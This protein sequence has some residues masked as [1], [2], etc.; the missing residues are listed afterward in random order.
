MIMGIEEAPLTENL[1]GG[2]EDPSAADS[3]SSTSG[4]SSGSLAMAADS[5]ISYDNPVLAAAAG[6]ADAC[7]FVHRV[8]SERGT[9]PLL[10]TVAP[11]LA[12]VLNRPL[13][14]GPAAITVDSTKAGGST[15]AETIMLGALL[16]AV[17][18]ATFGGC[19][20]R[21][22]RAARL[23][24]DQSKAVEAP[25]AASVAALA[26]S[27][28]DEDP[29]LWGDWAAHDSAEASS[30]SLSGGAATSSSGGGGALAAEDMTAISEAEAKA[31]EAEPY[32]AENFTFAVNDGSS[33][34]SSS[35]PSSS[36]SSSSSKGGKSNVSTFPV[37]G[38][39]VP[40]G[41]SESTLVAAAL[42]MPLLKLQAANA[43]RIAFLGTVSRL[44]T[45][46]ANNIGAM[47][48]DAQLV[49]LKG[50]E[51]SAPR[52]HRHNNNNSADALAALLMTPDF[53]ACVRLLYARPLELPPALAA[54]HAAT[55]S[56]R[57]TSSDSDGS[58]ENSSGGTNSGS[59]SNGNPALDVALSALTTALATAAPKRASALASSVVG[60]LL[61]QASSP[62]LSQVV[63]PGGGCA[64]M[65]GAGSGG[66]GGGGGGPKSLMAQPCAWDPEVTHNATPSN[67]SFRDNNTI[68]CFSN[69]TSHR[70]CYGAVGVAPGQVAQWKVTVVKQPCC[71]YVGVAKMSRLNTYDSFVDSSTCIGFSNFSGER[72]C[73]RE[74]GAYCIFR[75]DMRVGTITYITVHGERECPI[76]KSETLYPAIDSDENGE[77]KIQWDGPMLGGSSG[78]LSSDASA[79]AWLLPRT[80]EQK[81]LVQ[82]RPGLALA[83]L[84]ALLQS[85][86]SAHSNA[87]A[88][89]LKTVQALSSQVLRQEVLNAIVACVEASSSDDDD[90][91]SNSS[92]SNGKDQDELNKRAG[93][94]KLA[95]LRCVASFLEAASSSSLTSAVDVSSSSRGRWSKPQFDLSALQRLGK[96]MAWMHTQET[97]KGKGYSSYLMALVQVMASVTKAIDAQNDDTQSQIVKGR[98]SAGTSQGTGEEEFKEESSAAQE[99][100]EEAPKNRVGLNGA[101]GSEV[102][103]A[104]V[105]VLRPV[106]VARAGSGISGSSG[107][108]SPPP[109]PNCPSAQH[110][111]AVSDGSDNNGYRHFVCNGCRVHTSGFRWWC[112]HCR[113]DYCFSCHPDPRSASP[114][115]GRSNSSGGNTSSNNAASP[116]RVSASGGPPDGSFDPSTS[117]SFAAALPDWFNG[118]VH[119]AAALPDDPPL[120][121]V[122][123]AARES[124]SSSQQGLVPRSPV[125]SS[126]SS[127]SSS[128]SA[129]GSAY[130]VA[131][132][133]SMWMERNIIHDW[134]PAPVLRQ[135]IWQASSSFD[136]SYA[137]AN[138][139]VKSGKPW[140]SAAA[141]PQGIFTASLEATSNAAAGSSS[142]GSGGGRCEAVVVDFGVL[143]ELSGLR[144]HTPAQGWTGAE[145]KAL[146]LEISTVSAQGPWQPV[147]CGVAG[148]SP[149]LDGATTPSLP[150][151]CCP[152]GHPIAATQLTPFEGC[153]CSVCNREEIVGAC[154]TVYGCRSC[155]WGLCQSCYTTATTD[156][157][158]EAATKG[159]HREPARL[160]GAT[161][162]GAGA[163]FAAEQESVFPLEKTK[164][165]QD[166]VGFLSAARFWRLQFEG[167][168]GS[169]HLALQCVEFLG[170]V[171]PSLN[172]GHAACFLE[173][174][175]PPIQGGTDPAPTTSKIPDSSGG[176]SFGPIPES[177]PAPTAYNEDGKAPTVPP[178]FSLEPAGFTLE[179]W[180]RPSEA[181]RSGIQGEIASIALAGGGAVQW[182]LSASGALTLAV[183]SNDDSHDVHATSTTTGESSNTTT[184]L[185]SFEAASSKLSAGSWAHVAVVCAF[186]GSEHSSCSLVFNGEL[187]CHGGAAGSAC[188]QA[189][190]ALLQGGVGAGGWGG[191]T[192]VIGR[193]L[194]SPSP[195]PSSL[196]SSAAGAAGTTATDT[197]T[198]Q[199]FCG[200]LKELRVWRTARSS[201]AIAQYRWHKHAHPS[202]LGT[203]ARSFQ[204]RHGADKNLMVAL[205]LTGPSDSVNTLDL[206]WA[207][208]GSND[209]NDDSSSSSAVAVISR[210]LRWA[211][212]DGTVSLADA[213]ATTAAA[214]PTASPQADIPSSESN[215][216]LDPSSPSGQLTPD[217]AAAATNDE[218]ATTGAEPPEARALL[219]VDTSPLA[220]SLRLHTVTQASA[221]LAAQFGHLNFHRFLEALQG[222]P[223]GVD[224]ALVE[225]VN[226]ACANDASF[227]S[228][229]SNANASNSNNSGLDAYDKFSFGPQVSLVAYP[230]LKACAAKG[231]LNLRL[232]AAR[233]FNTQIAQLL[234]LVDLRE[235]T[236]PNTLA[237]ALVQAAPRLWLPTK[238]NLWRAGLQAT[239]GSGGSRSIEFSLNR[240][241]AA[242]VIGRRSG[243]DRVLLASVFGQLFTKVHRLPPS[244]LRLSASKDNRAWRVNFAGEGSIDAG[245]PYRESLSDA[246]GDLMAPHLALF[247]PCANQ[248]AEVEGFVSGMGG[249]QHMD[250]FVP[251]PTRQ[252]P[253]H[254]EMYQFAGKLL[255]LA[256][257]TGAALPLRFPPLFYKLLLGA[258][259]GRSDLK[260]IDK[261]LVDYLDA[262]ARAA[263]DPHMTPEL[264]EDLYGGRCFT[265]K[266]ACGAREVELLPGGSKLMLNL[267]NAS[268][269]VRLMFQYHLHEFDTQ[270]RWVAAGLATVV[271]IAVLRVFTPSQVELLV[272]GRRE[273]DLELLKRVTVYEP[274]YSPTHP[275]I[276]LFWEMMESFTHAERSMMLKFTWSRDRLPLRAEDFSNHFKITQLSPRSG[277]QSP[278]DL[279]PLGHTCF[280]TIDLPEYTSLAAM[281]AKCKYAI[282]NC[283]AI[284]IDGGGGGFEPA[285][286]NDTDSEEDEEEEDEEEEDEEEEDEE[287][288][289]DNSNFQTTLM[290]RQVS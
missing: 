264:F 20:C 112:R 275:T 78:A 107:S 218:A 51:L 216:P 150:P 48:K 10:A 37:P 201:E 123:E 4:D 158:V 221:E 92:G 16:A 224:E 1:G 128:N 138:L 32:P 156:M 31:F 127:S 200:C 261:F 66:G 164:E 161:A 269:F 141:P 151:P 119:A 177:P 11:A 222:Q 220:S 148:P 192:G 225:L 153:L 68:A 199:A 115:S 19:H 126:S 283:T 88:S 122:D 267:S 144:L 223:V 272:T 49:D 82:P 234:P 179:C 124:A 17:A 160:D 197:I 101:I 173:E 280:F 58:G 111:M 248:R 95:A 262:V 117:S 285:E 270:A 69:N 21:G 84:N 73:T 60:E 185:V 249:I 203:T 94:H 75:L 205:P 240:H 136:D 108:S 142:S 226:N 87:N 162:A 56:G 114:D 286:S 129:N 281:T 257:R 214:V 100:K 120:D 202:L 258:A 89:S 163:A 23:L 152:A 230:E 65:H 62:Q 176:L 198:N 143:V 212:P 43:A 139:T 194:P 159:S 196:S 14:F 232:L 174:S 55:N 7:A 229:A 8:R 80:V 79:W 53:F 265:A 259:V 172:D 228:S 282:E 213:R 165:P 103:V 35:S 36:S 118:F 99:F 168:F 233:H 29:R 252:S 204:L 18:A 24:L 54:V 190:E 217:P 231:Q 239:I 277:S 215:L 155:D 133:Q 59:S 93:L 105:A 34:S 90:D 290:T 91:S 109:P 102:D 96:R 268:N 271:P 45:N 2:V 211:A 254:A 266:S 207:A 39:A 74:V 287:E 219:R 15:S 210:R 251:N 104:S 28:E 182:G 250:K 46:L 33:S 253:L 72:N 183:S 191:A 22:L 26:N 195:R 42:A 157:A 86:S 131:F 6:A 170:A 67:L 106:T 40:P 140:L 147:D 81:A 167:N 187:A 171:E 137:A 209:K 227:S 83:L 77:Y 61:F 279:L 206:G 50:R 255:G 180:V 278:N 52:R 125:K 274:P 288:E 149:D 135:A 175:I 116:Q 289:D 110:P 245:G 145:P 98:S 235:A 246:A 63:P 71:A 284:D 41:L 30:L 38:Q 3:S 44:S 263:K 130:S 64:M 247:V 237:A 97:A 154:A 178:L 244:C 76:D 273:I 186:G 208:L 236:T 13:A 166:V 193:A 5:E 241:D 57:S 256:M 85:L 70:C 260:R 188:V 146:R 242:D 276:V 189:L 12:N 169:E 132:A 47:H 27:D 243:S 238:F 9:M 184:T 25:A 134:L 121:L 113:D 181:T